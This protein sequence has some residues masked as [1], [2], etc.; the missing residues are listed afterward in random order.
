LLSPSEFNSGA[1]N[2]SLPFLQNPIH[3]NERK[4]LASGL[5]IHARNGIFRDR[6]SHIKLCLDE[7]LDAQSGQASL[8]GTIAPF[9]LPFRSRSCTLWLLWLGRLRKRSY[10]RQL[11]QFFERLYLYGSLLASSS[12][13]HAL[14]L[15]DRLA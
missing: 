5:Y 11:Q 14:G 1:G 2:K 4:R 10:A 15:P 7:L 12:L 8:I 3:H 9:P 13:I 6:R